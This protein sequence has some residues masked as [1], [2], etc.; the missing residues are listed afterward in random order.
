MI[1]I[2]VYLQTAFQLIL[3]ISDVVSDGLLAEQYFDEWMTNAEEDVANIAENRN[4][5]LL[6]YPTHLHAQY[7]FMY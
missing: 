7:K 6:F 4:M 1:I 3:H 5:T 2:F